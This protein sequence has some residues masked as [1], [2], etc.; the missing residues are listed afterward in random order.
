LKISLFERSGSCQAVA[1][2]ELLWIFSTVGRRKRWIQDK[3]RGINRRDNFF[4]GE[5]FRRKI[6]LKLRLH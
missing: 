1:E 3:K 4:G 5:I 2:R 6:R